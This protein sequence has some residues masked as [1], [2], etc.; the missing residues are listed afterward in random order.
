MNTNIFF[1]NP[2]VVGIGSGIIVYGVS[3]LFYLLFK[4]NN[5]ENKFILSLKK[6]AKMI[7]SN[8]EIVKF[9]VSIVVVITMFFI[10]SKCSNEKNPPQPTIPY[11]EI[12]PNDTI[13][14]EIEMV[15]VK[16]G[17]FMW[18][19][20]SVNMKDYHIG[21]FQVTQAQWSAVMKTNP[22]EFKGNNH[23]VENVDWNEVQKFIIILND[24]T[25]KKYRLPTEVEW[26]YAA[27]G[28]IKSRGFIYSGSNK[29]DDVAWYEN[30]SK[31]RTHQVGMK[32]PNELGIHDMSGNVW[33]LC[34]ECQDIKNDCLYI[35]RGGSWLYQES[36][37]R[38]ANRDYTN[39]NYKSNGI[40]FRLV[41]E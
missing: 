9:I 35:I 10:T 13:S 16:G 32:N 34:G 5:G 37:V 12:V 24:S 40:G 28:G 17:S 1:E 29:V 3:S 8:P 15:F 22:S 25:G 19:G 4:N 39:H 31:A 7:F 26:V 27:S 38:I 21:K 20:T 6:I 23:P 36:Y 33:E 14:K 30:N 2:W 41:L 11:K 18:D